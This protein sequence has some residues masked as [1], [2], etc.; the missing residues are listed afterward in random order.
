MA[1]LGMHTAVIGQYL[2][3]D[4][5]ETRQLP[6]VSDADPTMLRRGRKNQHLVDRLAVNPKI[7]RSGPTAHPVNNHG[8]ANLL[9]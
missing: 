2:I 1:L 5:G 7:P 3:D 4:L 9:I 8:M 6:A